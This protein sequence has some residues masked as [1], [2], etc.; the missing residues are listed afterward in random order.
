MLD[1]LNLNLI[2][3]YLVNTCAEMGITMMRTA[4]SPI[5]NEGRD[6]SCVLFNRDGEMIAQADFVP[7]MVGAIVHAV[8]WTIEELGYEFFEPDDVVIHNDPY[9][10]GCHLPEHMVMK[11]IFIE[12]ELFG[13]AA[14]MAH[15][16]EI[17]GMAVG[18]FAAD[19]TDVHQEGL[20]IPPVKII[21]RGREV[22]DV[23]KM[24]L[25]NHRTPRTTWGDLHAMFG[26]LNVAEKR[27]HKLINKY[28]VQVIEEAINELIKYAE[29]Y[30]RAEIKEIP[31]GIYSFC[32]YIED[33]GVIPGKSYK[34]DCRVVVAG[35]SLLIDYTGSESQAAGAINCTYGVTASA[36]YNAVLQITNSKIP[37]NSGA[38]RPIKIVAPPGTVVNV[39]YPNPEVGGNS[40]IHGRI[41]DLLLA[42]FS[43][44]VPDK[45]NAA[46]GGGCCNL[47]FGGTHPDTGKYYAGYHFDAVG[48]GANSNSDGNHMLNE[49]GGNCRTIPV[50]VF[51]T[52]Y[53]WVVEEYSLEVDSGGSGEHRG[54][55][56]MRKIFRVT[57]PEITV[58]AVMDRLILRPY[59]L[60]GGEDAKNG[61]LFVKRRGEKGWKTFVD[62]FGTKSK[63]KFSRVVLKKGDK[64]LIISP[65]GGGFGN[66]SKRDLLLVLEDVKEG[67]VSSEKAR[68]DYGLIIEEKEGVYQFS[69]DERKLSR[70]N[71]LYKHS[72]S[73]EVLKG[74]PFRERSDL[75]RFCVEE[76]KAEFIEGQW[77]HCN[78]CGKLIP[79]KIFQVENDLEKI[80]CSNECIDIYLNIKD[81]LLSK[82]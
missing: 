37:R 16:T 7:S 27:I 26:S 19:A 20:R 56:G 4:Y 33:D 5:F 45:V 38:Y 48:W 30:M 71:A 82:L 6:F 49:L 21:S 10:G 15:F 76:G 47:L 12:N 43:L 36:T 62:A 60:F 72:P 25:A 35:D 77:K 81:G 17:G 22:A 75:R 9:R 1:Q 73:V 80:F 66:P 79:K 67:L 29:R 24:I 44:A 63:G 31:D 55:Y 41:V 42:C 2:N 18:G 51:E 40:E 52:K 46:S 11:P 8:Q 74:D 69:R 39:S 53:P 59:G 23:W 13:F 70:K 58:S 50:E 57:A 65:G 61:G 64:V 3:N 32:D 28:G 68:K 78:F 14:S 54:G 34:I